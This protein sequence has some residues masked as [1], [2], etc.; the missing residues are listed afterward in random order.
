MVAS[1]FTDS[2]ERISP[3]RDETKDEEDSEAVIRKDLLR[4]GATA[5][6]GGLAAVVVSVSSGRE[7]AKLREW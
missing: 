5:L 7:P 3:K 6:F 1:P 4:K 2:E